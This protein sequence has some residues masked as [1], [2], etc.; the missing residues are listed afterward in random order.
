LRTYVLDASAL[1]RY[2]DKEAGYDRVRELLRLHA[3]NESALV[4]S[5]V[6]WGE[7]ACKV[8]QRHDRPRYEHILS[9]LYSIG[10]TITPATAER[11]ASAGILRATLKIAYADAF[12]VQAAMEL[13]G[14]VLVT[15]D[16]GFKAAEHLVKM[17]YLPAK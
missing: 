13:P 15:A 17:E 5:A 4:I 1:L 2:L 14:C 3:R 9:Q 11:A 16:Y 12:C 6:Q 8:F 10:L 7:I